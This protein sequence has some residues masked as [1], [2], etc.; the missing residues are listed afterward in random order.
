LANLWIWNGPR[1]EFWEDE[2]GTVNGNAGPLR[3]RGKGVLPDPKAKTAQAQVVV[4]FEAV[5]VIG[6]HLFWAETVSTCS[7]VLY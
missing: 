2:E 4:S 3:P 5:D 7:I 1:H 6:A